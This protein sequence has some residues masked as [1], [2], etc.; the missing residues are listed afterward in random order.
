MIFF[1]ASVFDKI[2]NVPHLEEGGKDIGWLASDDEE[3]RVQLP[4]TAIQVLQALQQ[5]SK[6][7]LFIFRK[8]PLTSI[9]WASFVILPAI[10]ADILPNIFS[11]TA[12][13]LSIG[14]LRHQLQKSN[15]ITVLLSNL[16]FNR[17]SNWEKKRIRI[18]KYE[19]LNLQN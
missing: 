9:N 11:Q 14:S 3:A 4:Q 8:K 7:I 19:G 16:P 5:K 2:L 15:K 17:L 1:L 12:K 13:Y 18:S 10:T 6:I